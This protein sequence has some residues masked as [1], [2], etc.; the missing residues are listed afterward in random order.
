MAATTDDK[1]VFFQYLF[2]FHF[3][4]FYLRQ[5]ALRLYPTCREPVNEGAHTQLPDGNKQKYNTV[6]GRIMEGYTVMYRIRHVKHLS[7]VKPQPEMG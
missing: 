4:P 2:S 1:I 3:L 7:Y 6:R 5:V